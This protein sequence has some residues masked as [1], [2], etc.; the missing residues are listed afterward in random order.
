MATAVRDVELSAGPAAV[1]DVADYRRCM[2]VFRWRGVVIG[3]AFVPVTGAGLSAAEVAD[4]AKR[5]L[6]PEAVRTWIEDIM[7]F[8]ERGERGRS[9]PSVAV[10][11]CTRERPDDLERTLRAVSALDPPPR[12]ILVIDNAPTTARTKKVA[13]NF[14]GVRYIIEPRQGLNRARNRALSEATADVVA[15]TDDD[16]APEPHWL[17]ALLRELPG[18]SSD[19]RDRTDAAVQVETPA[20]ELFEEHCSFVRGCTPRLQRAHRQPAAR[21]ACSAARTWR[22]ARRLVGTVGRFD[23]RLDAGTPTMS[24]GDHEML[25]G[26]LPRVSGWSTNHRR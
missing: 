5:H 15:F 14:P 3:R 7:E 13:S 16:A 23:E 26:F 10:A 19:V 24:G 11:I 2:L 1:R 22:C 21:R 4:I 8:D 12:E 9:L 6:T 25:R 18:S 17:R 20:Q